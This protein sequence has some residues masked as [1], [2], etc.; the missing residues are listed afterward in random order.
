M[1]K[2]SAGNNTESNTH[3]DMDSD[4]NDE[5]VFVDGEYSDE[6]LPSHQ[7]LLTSEEFLPRF[8]CVDFKNGEVRYC[9]TPVGSNKGKAYVCDRH[10]HVLVEGASGKGKSRGVTIPACDTCIEMGQSVCYVTTK[11]SDV[12]YL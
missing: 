6:K 2:N 4:L 8:K 11:T 5:Y 10:F 1:N 9:G 7:R 3:P 12:G